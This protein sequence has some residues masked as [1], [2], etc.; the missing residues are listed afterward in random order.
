MTD[1]PP[2]ASMLRALV[3]NIT[4]L[5]AALLLDPQLPT[6]GRARSSRASAS[7]N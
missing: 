2:T 1:R 3:T 6:P 4:E 5:E 7:G